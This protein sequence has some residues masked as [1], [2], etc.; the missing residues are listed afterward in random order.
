MIVDVIGDLTKEHPLR[1]ENAKRLTEK[2]WI[3]MRQVV[4]ILRRRLENEPEPNI[5]IL[6]PIGS[7]VWDMWRVVDHRV[8]GT[9][10]KRLPPIVSDDVGAEVR[11]DVETDHRA[12]AARP[13][14]SCISGGIQ[15]PFGTPSRVK[16]EHAL[17]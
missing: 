6:R 12:F 4:T 1:L 11:I 5:E 14:S 7:L 16:V 8:E 15:N 10:C 2:G 3:K 13:E 17:E 9:V